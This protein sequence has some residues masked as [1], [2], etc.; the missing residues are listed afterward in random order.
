MREKF[1]ITVTN[2]I[3]GCPIVKYLDPI[4]SN[5]VI[6]TNIFSDIAASFSDFFGGTSGTYQNKLESI[7]EKATAS[8][9][10]KAISL[11][12]NAIIGFNVDFDE[13]SGSGKSMFMISA[14]GTACIID[15]QKCQ[16]DNL[17]MNLGSLSQA[18][19]DFEVEKRMI[20]KHINEKK[21]IFQP[22]MEFLY[23]YP[24]KEIVGTLLDICYTPES[25]DETNAFIIKYLS[26][27]PKSDVVDELYSKIETK[28]VLRRLISRCAL[29]SPSHILN[30]VKRDPKTAVTL[31][32]AKCDCYQKEDLVPMK[33][34][35]EIYDALPDTGKIEMVKG[36]L[37]SKDQE[38]YICE[39]G[40]KNNKDQIFCEACGVNIKGWDKKQAQLIDEF[41]TKVQVLNDLL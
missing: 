41:R 21:Q 38:K 35:I 26:L 2:N 40:H 10:G 39:N 1:I 28:P 31:L 27:L 7:Y 18:A 23:E 17:M 16:E 8:L 13:I 11:G 33:E 25:N 34:I 22:W 6:G 29:F 30:I 4:C 36:G 3:E 14:S 9:R 5:V 15:N 20:I 37:L 12:A 19:L 24:Q 32:S